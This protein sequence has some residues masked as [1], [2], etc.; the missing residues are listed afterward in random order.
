MS[1]KKSFTVLS[2]LL[3]FNIILFALSVLI[4]LRVK[5]DLESEFLY[6][7]SIKENGKLD[8]FIFKLLNRKKNVI[9]CRD[10]VDSARESGLD[11]WPVTAGKFSDIEILIGSELDIDDPESNVGSIFEMRGIWFICDPQENLI[12]IV[13]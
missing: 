7:L 8:S 1:I 2:F 13:D 5:N 3:L 11:I 10:I 12:V 4:G 6:E 9:S